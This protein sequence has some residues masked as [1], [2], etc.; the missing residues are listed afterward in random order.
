MVLQVYRL[1]SP[2]HP[3]HNAFLVSL[4]ESPRKLVLPQRR[5]KR[6]RLKLQPFHLAWKDKLL[7]P[8]RVRRSFDMLK[9]F[10]VKHSSCNTAGHEAER[11]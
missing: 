8:F 5:L 6:K 7:G 9:R 4:D 1:V 11:S 3:L 2:N 10:V